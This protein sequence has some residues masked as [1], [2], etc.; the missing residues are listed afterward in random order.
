MGRR[1]ECREFVYR[2]TWPL[3]AVCR[4]GSKRTAD[5]MPLRAPTTFQFPGHGDITTPA[6]PQRER[7]QV[8]PPRLRFATTPAQVLAEMIIFNESRIGGSRVLAAYSKPRPCSVMLA[9]RYQARPTR[10]RFVT[11]CEGSRQIACWRIVP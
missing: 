3:A 8:Y 11:V 7:A 10:R 2:H 4:L 9:L 1:P 6:T 5:C